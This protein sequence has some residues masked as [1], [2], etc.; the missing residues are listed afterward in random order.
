MRRL[1]AQPPGNSVSERGEFTELFALDPTEFV[2]ARDQLVRERKAAGDKAGA[3]AVKAL[4]RPTVP[5]WA[6]NQVARQDPDTVD[7]LVGA[8][9]DARAA[10]G[11]VLDGG[12]PDELRDALTRRR[13][14][15]AAVA[16][17]ARSVLTD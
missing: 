1:G 3:A 9:A 5:L 14:A 2:A 7:A 17:A 4:K 10:Q 6:L 13:E 15:L 11:A 8:A 16:R 12:K